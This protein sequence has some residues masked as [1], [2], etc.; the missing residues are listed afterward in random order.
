MGKNLML[1]PNSSTKAK[2][3]QLHTSCWLLVELE[4]EKRLA[5]LESGVEDRDVGNTAGLNV[6]VACDDTLYKRNNQ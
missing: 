3:N 5:T 2:Y 6:V 1:K 4:T